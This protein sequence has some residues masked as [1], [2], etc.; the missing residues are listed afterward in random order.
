MNSDFSIAIHCLLLL[1]DQTN[2]TVTSD[3]IANSACVHP[4]RIRKVLGILK[5]NG[6]I[7]SKE[8]A[9]G[10]FY[11][12]SDPSQITLDE[13]YQLTSLGTLQPKCPQKNLHCPIG[14]NIKEVLQSIFYEA[15]H[16]V[17]LFLHRFTIRDVLRLIKKTAE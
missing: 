12:S 14:A 13:I 5:R 9:G 8:G 2:S 1:A 15:E 16:Q 17:E 3:S 7:G 6:Y 4:V 11:L 10:G